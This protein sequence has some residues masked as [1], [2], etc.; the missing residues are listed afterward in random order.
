MKTQKKTK[1]KS[2]LFIILPYMVLIRGSNSDGG[3]VLTPP[4][5]VLSI[6]SYI[7]KN[8]TN[9]PS[10]SILDLNLYPQ[11]ERDA[12]VLV[13]LETNQPDI[14][15]ISMMFDFCYKHLNQVSR[16]IKE[17]NNNVVVVVGGNS[18]TVSW[19]MILPEQ[20][21]V[22]AICYGE[23]ELPLLQLIEAENIFETLIN[24]PTWVTRRSLVDKRVPRVNYLSDLNDL[25]D[26][27]YELI[28]VEDYST[29][30]AFSPF[31][32]SS[33]VNKVKQFLLVTSRGC[34]FKC[35]FCAAPA[36]HG[37]KI[38]YA[39]VD[40]VIE[41]VR[42]LVKKYNINVLTIHDDQILLN[43]AR[44]RD[45]FRRL[46]EF[47][48]RVEIPS[49]LSVAFVDEEIA[50]LMKAA[51]VDT[52]ILAIESGSSRVLNEIIRKPLRLEQVKP[53]IEILRNNNMFIRACFVVGLPGE[54][55]EDRV[56]TVR[57]IKEV[58]LDWASFNLATPLR[59]SELY[60]ICL[61]NGYIDPSFGIGDLGLHDYVINAPGLIPEDIKRK[62]YLMNLDVN[63]VNNYR[64]RI[65]DYPI[66]RACFEDVATRH[67]NHAFA[68]YYLAKSLEALNEDKEKINETM[69]R[70]KKIISEDRVW[71][72]YFDYFD[73][74]IKAEINSKLK[75]K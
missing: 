18:A 23:G 45:F 43:R 3:S 24:D 57:F 69:F 19:N 67:E 52:A 34:P 8:A 4:Y 29:K 26:V 41:H 55:D 49:G 74:D 2:V 11:E 39:D 5:G 1:S 7:K 63:F 36:L 48:L 32:L 13:A 50:E 62:S 56:E 20:G 35:V 15:G 59:G 70:V 30:E 61:E 12:A 47:K 44:A 65:G 27:D 71:Q 31:S 40:K 33:T 28:N 17:Y 68:H 75:N 14:V 10:I 42:F 21:H 46:A 6:S 72:E 16:T 9:V 22:D 38:R 58:E 54:L 51:G 60:R 64:M 25:I 37:K 73:V 53:A 66:A